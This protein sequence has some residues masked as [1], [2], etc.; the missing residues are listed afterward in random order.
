M[1]LYE[2]IS[3]HVGRYVVVK[4]I[5]LPACVFVRVSGLCACVR[6]EGC[7]L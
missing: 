2:I 1:P 6:T 7:T 5:V 4:V 3:V